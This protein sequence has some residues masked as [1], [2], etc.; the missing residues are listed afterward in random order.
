MISVEEALSIVLGTT[1]T[2]AIEENALINSLN[3]VCAEN[4]TASIT[5][6]PWDNS[7]MDGFAVKISDVESASE[8]SG[9]KLKVKADIPAGSFYSGIIRK[10]ECARIMTGAPVPE[11]AEAV[12]MREYADDSG[13]EVILKRSVAKGE[14]IRKKGEDI[15]IGDIVVPEGKTITSADIGVMASVQASKISV[16]KNPVVAILSTGDELVDIDEE[17]KPGKIVTSNNYALEAQ[18]IE[19]GALPLQMGIIKDNRKVLR[20]AVEKAGTADIIL[21]TGGVSVGDYDFVK[22]VLGELG[23]DK[24]F[25]KVAQKPGKPLLFGT[26]GKSFVFGLPGNPTATMLCFELYVR[27]VIRKFQGF[28]KIQRKKIRA[29]ALEDIN[30]KAGRTHFIRVITE[31]KD[32]KYFF[33]TTGAQGSG[34]LT[35]MSK[36]NSIAVVDR[37]ATLLKKGEC[38]DVILI[39]ES[40]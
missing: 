18:I 34:I 19:S 13:D 26:M 15:N 22:E 20:R 39:D 30:K 25:W 11:G 2:P 16:Y 35:S 23:F 5:V 40:I 24:K 37:N 3:R 31:N 21:T 28:T 7:A 38:A 12:V 17:I 1:V 9:I 29:E 4:V 14:N 33:R 36:A 32:G 8:S 6:P 10:G 27:P